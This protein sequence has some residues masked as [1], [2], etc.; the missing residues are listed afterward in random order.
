MANGSIIG[1]AKFEQVLMEQDEQRKEEEYG[2]LM[3]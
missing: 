3:K 2:R 1:P